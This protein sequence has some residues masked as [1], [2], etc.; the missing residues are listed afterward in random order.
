MK[1]DASQACFLALSKCSERFLS[2]LQNTFMRNVSCHYPKEMVWISKPAVYQLHPERPCATLPALCLTFFIFSSSIFNCTEKVGKETS[3][4]NTQCT[5]TPFCLSFFLSTS[6]AKALRILDLGP[7]AFS[8]AELDEECLLVP[9]PRSPEPPMIPAFLNWYFVCIKLSG[10][11]IRTCSTESS[12]QIFTARYEGEANAS[13]TKQNWSPYRH[14][15][16]LRSKMQRV[17]HRYDHGSPSCPSGTGCNECFCYITGRNAVCLLTHNTN[18]C[19]VIKEGTF[20]HGALTAS[21]NVL[22]TYMP[23]LIS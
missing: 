4:Q 19:M 23:H 8:V 14:S 16:S 2:F 1:E 13:I 15:I 6:A 12:L 18:F 9:A 22:L 20:E 10:T 3:W 17:V 21:M 5:A 7:A 11:Y